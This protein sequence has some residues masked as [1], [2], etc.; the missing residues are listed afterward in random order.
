MHVI[1]HAMSYQAN[2]NCVEL[3]QLLISF[4][5]G[6]KIE[7]YAERLVKQYDGKHGILGF[8]I[9]MP[10]NFETSTPVSKMNTFVLSL[11]QR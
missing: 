1:V 8:T 7:I 11:Q 10:L 4:L 5:W 9:S 2:F 3:L 6:N